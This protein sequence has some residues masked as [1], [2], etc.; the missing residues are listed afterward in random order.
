MRSVV[1]RYVSLLLLFLTYTWLL[2]DRGW[3]SFTAFAVFLSAFIGQ[4]VYFQRLFHKN[5][6]DR[7]HD[8]KLFDILLSDLPYE[9]VIRYLSEIDHAEGIRREVV[10]CVISFEHYWKS[11]EKTFINPRL[12]KEKEDLVRKLQQYIK[13]CATNTF[14]DEANRDYQGV[15]K[16]WRLTEPETYNGVTG[17][18]N[19]AADRVVDVYKQLLKTGRKRL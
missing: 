12:Q 19:E 17:Q 5:E 1:S 4:D 18:L 11:P 3:E 6:R 2:M 14:R 13:L 9:G 7:E 10:K 15:P 8:Q 16:E